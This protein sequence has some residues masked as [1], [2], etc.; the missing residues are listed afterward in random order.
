MGTTQAIYEVG[1]ADKKRGHHFFR[2][3]YLV[4]PGES[5]MVPGMPQIGKLEGQPSKGTDLRISYI[6]VPPLKMLI[7]V[8]PTD[9]RLPQLPTVV[10]PTAISP[11]LQKYTDVEVAEP[12]KVTMLKYKPEKRCTIRYDHLGHRAGRHSSRQS[13]LIGKTFHDDRGRRIFQSLQFL[14]GSG[15]PV[16]EPVAYVPDLRLL[17]TE[18]VGGRELGSLVS[19]PNFL[20]YITGAARS[21]AGL[22]SL[23]IDRKLAET[24]SLEERANKFGCLVEQSPEECLAPN[25]Q[26]NHLAS[27][28]ISKLKNCRSDHLAFVHGS[29]DPSQLIIGESTIWLVDFDS[30]RISHPATDVGRFLAYL[31]RLPIRWLYGD[32]S[33]LDTMGERFL[34]E[35]LALSLDDLRGMI[36]ICQ[37]MECVKISF[38]ISRRQKSGWQSRS[39]SMLE[40]AEGVLS[41]V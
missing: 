18:A 16:P 25:N 17:L 37:A 35:Y 8:F 26:V 31:N 32:P 12:L 6:Y 29:L 40:I 23:P 27:A 34:E 14:K 9:M 19:D 4:I 36:L 20:M 21:V 30:F 24:V 15:L 13:S 28:I 39:A 1:F 41:R 2:H 11:Y 33:H 7:Q 5:R 38:I 22:H 10:R 3:L